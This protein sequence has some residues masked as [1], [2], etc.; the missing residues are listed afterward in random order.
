MN[1]NIKFLRLYQI[2]YKPAR[3]DLGILWYVEQN[4][5]E[6][7][8]LSTKTGRKTVCIVSMYNKSS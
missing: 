1:S 3:Y 4:L 6:R 5:A 8:A 2:Q 7:E